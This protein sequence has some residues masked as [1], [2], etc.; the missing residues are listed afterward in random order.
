MNADPETLRR[1][2]LTAM[3]ARRRR[4]TTERFGVFDGPNDT[5][6]YHEMPERRTPAA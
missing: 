3:L 1:Q 5:I 4:Y 6:T 2:R